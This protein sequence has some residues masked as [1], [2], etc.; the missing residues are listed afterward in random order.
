MVIIATK[1]SKN[2]KIRALK[3]F[4]NSKAIIMRD[5]FIWGKSERV[6]SGYVL[7]HTNGAYYHKDQANISLLIE[8]IKAYKFNR[9][10]A[11]L[12]WPFPSHSSAMKNSTYENSS[13]YVWE[14]IHALFIWLIASFMSSLMMLHSSL[15]EFQ[16]MGVVEGPFTKASR[17]SSQK[18][19]PMAEHLVACLAHTLIG[20]PMFTLVFAFFPCSDHSLYLLQKCFTIASH[21]DCCLTVIQNLVT[22]QACLIILVVVK[23]LLSC[24][25][26]DRDQIECK[27]EAWES[28]LGQSRSKFLAS[29]FTSLEG[30]VCT[31]L[32]PSAPTSLFL[33]IFQILIS[34][35]TVDGSKK[36]PHK[37][38]LNNNNKFTED[39]AESTP[40]QAVAT[41]KLEFATLYKVLYMHLQ[42]DQTT[43]LLYLMLHKNHDFRTYVLSRTDIESLVMPIL[44]TLYHAP[45]S[46]SHH[47]YMSLI[48]LLILSEDDSF[49]KTIHDIPLKSITWYTER[50]IT[51][52]SLGGLLILVVIRTIT[53]N[54]TKMRDKYLHTNCLAALANMSSQ[55][56][57]LHPYVCQRLVSLFETLSKRHGRLTDMLKAT[58]YLPE[59]AENEVP[60]ALSDCSV[61]EEVLRMVLEILNSTLT[62]QLSHN[63]N[64]VYTLLYKR[65]L[66]QAFSSHPSFQDVTQ[67]I[68]VVLSYLMGRLETT[69]R[70]PAVQDVQEVIQQGVLH[71][72]K[73]R[74]KKFPELKF[75]YVEENEPE[76]FFI[77][78]VWTLVYQSSGLYW[79]PECIAMF[80][81]VK[82]NG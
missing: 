3:E 82:H 9:N 1:I 63:H 30:P 52:I 25:P 7:E 17:T 36:R 74:L 39:P 68:E 23:F 41:F 33:I 50:L 16:I 80:V 67:N 73:D 59:G 5:G 27:G 46:T 48:I 77:P 22:V 37:N 14:I 35:C 57:C 11:T 70:D 51:E 6:L 4:K 69:V 49:N 62:H 31:R 61:L 60:D 2:A 65:H 19:M 28:A 10:I 79:D 76:E 56:R 78:Y 29:P 12:I 43:L 47:I 15:S 53:Y 32:K 34:I 54:M 20:D 45:D 24:P 8:H 64:L 42:D 75:K 21:H 44:H 81:M 26:W 18:D 66:F 71:L 55:F 13:A 72:P 38:I 40:T 58:E